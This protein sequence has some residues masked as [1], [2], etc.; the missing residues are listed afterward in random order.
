[1]LAE[2]FLLLAKASCSWDPHLE[3][4][5]GVCYFR[6]ENYKLAIKHFESVLHVL[7]NIQSKVKVW[8]SVWSNLAQAYLRTGYFQY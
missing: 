6:K 2:E 5:L 7:G 1:M 3:N 8:G 4:E